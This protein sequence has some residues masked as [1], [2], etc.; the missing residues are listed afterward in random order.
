M[1][2][3]N[4]FEGYNPAPLNQGAVDRGVRTT[5]GAAT[6]AFTGGLMGA[7]LTPLVVGA[8]AALGVGLIGLSA[9]TL[10]GALGFGGGV[11]SALAASSPVIGSAMTVVGIIGTGAGV[12][13]GAPLGG[14]LGGVVGAFKGGSTENTRAN[15]DQS[16]YNISVAE[17][18][19]RAQA[20]P[21]AYAPQGVQP[22]ARD[23][24]EAP[25]RRDDYAEQMNA[26]KPVI[27]ANSVQH[28]GTINAN[29]ALAR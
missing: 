27:A 6:G 20:Q 21:V 25:K 18:I 23:A 13:F 16:L 4:R 11:F 9:V 1:A 8:T 10:V 28:D 14:F 12:I 17:A 7:M 24:V 26:A 19:G 15:L 29:L 3:N 2:P 22:I 5:A